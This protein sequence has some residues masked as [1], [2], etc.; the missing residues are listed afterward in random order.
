MPVVYIG[1]KTPEP[2]PVL[3]LEGLNHPVLIWAEMESFRLTADTARLKMVWEPLVRY[4]NVLRKYL[5][6]GNGLY[7]ADWGQMDNSPRNQWL[8][9][10]G[11]AVDIS[12]EMVLFA[13][14]LSDMAAIIGKQDE[15][16]QI[17]GP[18]RFPL[19]PYQRP[20]VECR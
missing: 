13:R 17:P 19:R 12:S 15:V 6:Q 2:P 11:T 1:R 9:N 14:K 8:M 7:I 18:G 10:G 4:Y 3:T 5:R 20:D 16:D